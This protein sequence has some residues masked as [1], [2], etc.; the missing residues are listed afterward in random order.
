MGRAPQW[1]HAIAQV[2]CPNELTSPGGCWGVMRQS[3]GVLDSLQFEAPTSPC[4]GT[5]RQ[6]STGSVGHSMVITANAPS[7]TPPPTVT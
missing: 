6:R 2:S 3:L 1:F 4:L 7:I 5:H